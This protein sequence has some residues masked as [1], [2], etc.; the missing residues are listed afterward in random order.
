MEPRDL[1]LGQMSRTINPKAG[2]GIS[3]KHHNGANVAFADG[4]IS[5]LPN[6]LKPEVLN[7]LLSRNGHESIPPD[8]EW[9]SAKQ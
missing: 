5:L 9:S 3:S 8:D 1:Y 4:H 6:G 7:A 2:Q